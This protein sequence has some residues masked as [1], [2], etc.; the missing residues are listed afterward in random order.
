MQRCTPQSV[1]L[2]VLFAAGIIALSGPV[3]AQE[4]T[5]ISYNILNYPGSTG[6]A[7][8]PHFRTVLEASGPDLLVVQE[9]IGISGVN[10]FMANV[11]EVLEPG[12]WIAAPHHDGPDTDRALFLRA[13]LGEIL[14]WGNL[15]TDLQ[16]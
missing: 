7:R 16:W 9:V 3:G 11:L 13:E 12:A 5:L 1:C 4:V 14:D 6:T 15:S 10:H 8:A 2:L